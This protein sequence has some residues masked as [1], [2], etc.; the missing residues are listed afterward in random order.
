MPEA[1][2]SI[3]DITDEDIDWVRHLMDLDVLDAPRRTFLLARTTLDV[4]ACPGSGKT[5]LIVAKLAILAR[6]WPYRTKGICVLS[7][8]NV[9]REE[10]QRRLGG[11][12]IGQRLLDYPHFIDTIH[13]FVNRF[14]ALPWLHSNGYPSPTIDDGVTAAV[15]RRALTQAEHFT[16]QTFLA[17]KKSGLDHL[18]ICARDLRFDLGGKPFPAGPHTNS[19]GIAKK[20]VEAAAT[21]GYFCYDEMF[22]WARALLE[23]RPDI[24]SWLRRRFPL[25]LI[26]EMQDTSE[27]QGTMLQSVF[28]RTS[29]DVVVQR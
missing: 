2:S 5:T 9:A 29:D 10:I 12:V 4:S 20:A 8:T 19:F 24:A 7:H 11:T 15:R 22:V 25:V 6:K 3:P 26:D 27:L 23:D 1:L 18:R 13:G 16:I 14:L 21:A 28:S 17:N